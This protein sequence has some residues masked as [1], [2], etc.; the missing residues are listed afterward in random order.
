MLNNPIS[1]IDPLGDTTRVYNMQGEL[2]RTIIDSHAN[3]EHFLTDRNLEILNGAD[4]SDLDADGIGTAFRNG[5]SFF[6]GA[7]TRDQLQAIVELAESEGLERAYTLS[8]SATQK[9]LQVND[10]TGNRSRTS[11]SINL[12]DNISSG[13]GRDVIVGHVHPTA[14][15]RNVRVDPTNAARVN[16]PSGSRG[17]QDYQSLLT[18]DYSRAYPQMISSVHGYNVYTSA[19][20]TPAG[21]SHPAPYQ[22]LSNR[23]AIINYSGVKIVD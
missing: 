12:P 20:N 3:Q 5:S 17:L 18:G 9:E 13:N 8:F 23:G 1:N 7:N 14:G 10:I 6:I 22:I 15:A 2:V 16:S 4:H 19:R 21:S 11:N